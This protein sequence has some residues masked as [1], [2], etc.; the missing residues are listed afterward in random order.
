MWL[1]SKSGSYAA[2]PWLLKAHG[3]GVAKLAQTAIQIFVMGIVC[4]WML[5]TVYT[6]GQSLH[7]AL[8][9]FQMDNS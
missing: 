9:L 1:I 8:S 4:T 5:Q 7:R 3:I 2:L 6:T